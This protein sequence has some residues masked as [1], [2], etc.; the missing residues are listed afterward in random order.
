M[1]HHSSLEVGTINARER[2]QERKPK[3]YPKKKA[4]MDAYF[5]KPPLSSKRCHVPQPVG[6]HSL[7]VGNGPRLPKDSHRHGS[8]DVPQ[9]GKNPRDAQ[10]VIGEKNVGDTPKE[11]SAK[12]S[13]W[14]IQ[15]MKRRAKAELLKSHQQ[16]QGETA[17]QPMTASQTPS[18]LGT[19]I[20][21]TPCLQKPV[22]TT[23]VVG[24]EA[25]V[26]N[27]SATVVAVESTGKPIGR[28]SNKAHRQQRPNGQGYDGSRGKGSSKATNEPP[29]PD[30]AQLGL[31]AIQNAATSVVA[32][33]N[34]KDKCKRPWK[35]FNPGQS[36]GKHGPPDPRQE[37]S[38][39]MYQHP[40]PLS[41]I[42]AGGSFCT[43]K[44]IAFVSCTRTCSE[45]HQSTSTCLNIDPNDCT[46]CR[47]ESNI[48]QI[49]VVRSGTNQSPSAGLGG[50]ILSLERSSKTLFN[51]QPGIAG[52]HRL[53][54]EPSYSRKS[55]DPAISDNVSSVSVNP[56]RKSMP[57]FFHRMMY[58][59]FCLLSFKPNLRA[60]LN[61]SYN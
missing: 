14:K 22:H 9:P 4:A 6:A 1:E 59:C 18:P 49:S 29:E 34:G 45:S 35:S 39:S 38:E 26:G 10:K 25:N 46:L 56:N 55:F 8:A 27:I 53:L 23:D 21:S 60:G 52:N 13:K 20:P 30:Q 32:T 41:P 57:S 24:P 31:A 15:R 54:P 36:A 37:G 43:S 58:W 50:P 33:G 51:A 7:L 48:V 47:K 2:T 17:D 61:F 12:P 5:N 11:E 28:D 3:W 40:S 16:A 44:V 42:S 19:S